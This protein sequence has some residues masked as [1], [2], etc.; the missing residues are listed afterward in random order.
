[1]FGFAFTL[2]YTVLI[3]RKRE[4]IRLLLVDR[5]EGMSD[6]RTVTLDWLQMNGKVNRM[7]ARIKKR[8]PLKIQVKQLKRQR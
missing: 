4:E 2:Y 1:M 6:K 3:I 5:A 8:Q 7:H